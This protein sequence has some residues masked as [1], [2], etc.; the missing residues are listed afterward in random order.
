V[1]F[2]LLHDKKSVEVS[3]KELTCPEPPPTVASGQAGTPGFEKQIPSSS[4][5]GRREVQALRSK[6]LVVS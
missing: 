1:R 6:F 3:G 2:L 4:L 5:P